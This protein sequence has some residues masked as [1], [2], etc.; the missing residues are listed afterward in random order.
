[1]LWFARRL[2]RR[3]ISAYVLRTLC[4]RSGVRSTGWMSRGSRLP[5]S[6]AVS[7]YS[8]VCTL[9]SV[10]LSR[11]PS[12]TPSDFRFPCHL[13][14]LSIPPTPSF[15]NP[16]RP[17]LQSC[18]PPPATRRAAALPPT[19]NSASSLSSPTLS[20]APTAHCKVKFGATTTP[21]RPL[22]QTACNESDAV[23]QPPSPIFVSSHP[24][25]KPPV[26]D[27]CQ[28]GAC[29]A[30]RRPPNQPAQR[31]GVSDAGR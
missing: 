2:A 20:T 29:S 5:S 25:H 24:S 27:S 15:R 17:L 13:P 31:P 21:V 10:Q 30:S 11:N 28:L 19:P 7:R 8:F 22:R 4:A 12:V 14:P 3:R 6:R 18:A 23:G 1:M 9:T 26:F 16:A